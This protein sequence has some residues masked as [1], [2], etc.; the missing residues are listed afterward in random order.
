MMNINDAKDLIIAHPHDGFFKYSL[1]DLALAKEFI[2]NYLPDKVVKLLDLS[3]MEPV[4]DSFVDE[5]LKQYFTDMLFKINLNGR[6]A[7]SY[8]LFEHKSSAD[9][10]ISLQ[11]LGYIVKIWKMVCSQSTVEKL[12]VIIP[13]VIYHGAKPWNVGLKLSDLLH[14]VPDAVKEHVPDYKYI[15]HDLSLLSDEE[16]K[17]SIKVRLFVEVLANAFKRD[18]INKMAGILQ[19]IAELNKIEGEGIYGEVALLYI[20]R[21]RNDLPV[22]KIVQIDREIKT[23]MEG[24]IMSVAEQLIEKGREEGR[25]EG[26]EK[27]KIRTARKMLMKGMQIDDVVEL[28]ELPKDEVLKLAEKKIA[29]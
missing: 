27:A 4:R 19:L 8:F 24:L 11:L 3:S 25:E 18:I 9:R 16:I 14:Q 7:Y 26:M 28:T 2:N 21:V 20:M 5:E 1:Q 15:L 23:N 10:N 12:P 29:L 22:K 6:T 17:G 13:L